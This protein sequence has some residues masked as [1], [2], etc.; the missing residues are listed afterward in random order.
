MLAAWY[1]SLFLTHSTGRYTIVGGDSGSI[2][3]DSDLEMD[4]GQSRSPSPEA[5]S[6]SHNNRRRSAISEASA[7]LI[8][9]GTFPHEQSLRPTV[10]QNMA[11]A[12]LQQ[13]RDIT[14]GTGSRNS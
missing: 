11:F 13:C 3:S 8:D 1:S 7:I 9:P 5:S 2:S 4:S 12:A 6:H 10:E 14:G